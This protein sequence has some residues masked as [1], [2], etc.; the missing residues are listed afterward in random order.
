MSCGFKVFVPLLVH[1]TFLVFVNCSYWWDQNDNVG[2]IYTD[3]KPVEI[4]NHPYLVSIIAVEYTFDG[5]S[6]KDNFR[7]GG[8]IIKAIHERYG[9]V[10]TAG[11]CLHSLKTN[12]ISAE[13]VRVRTN[14]EYWMSCDCGLAE[15]YMIHKWHLHPDYRELVEPYGTVI[16]N[17]IGLIAVQGLWRGDYDRASLNKPLQ[18]ARWPP[19]INMREINA[20]TLGWGYTKSVREVSKEL[21]IA[22][23]F[24]LTSSDDCGK[25]YKRN[26]PFNTYCIGPADRSSGT[27]C[28]F[29]QGGPVLWDS[30]DGKKYLIGI[31][32]IAAWCG[33]VQRPTIVVNSSL[34]ADFI[35]DVAWV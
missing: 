12:H 31:T 8:A 28:A 16:H 29:D 1:L 27:P 11:S 33:D 14:S 32:S 15:S 18:Y 10:L 26:V 9:I 6:M 21:Q 34:F 3:A 25:Y 23:G 22:V 4:G 7:C 17:D 24:S 35:N 30:S 5:I 20:Y 19:V 2:R 13:N